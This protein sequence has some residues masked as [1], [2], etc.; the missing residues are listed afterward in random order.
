MST[1]TKQVAKFNSVQLNLVYWVDVHKALRNQSLEGCVYAMDNGID[2]ENQGTD[3]LITNCKQGQTLNWIIYAMDAIQLP[4]GSWPASVRINNIVFLDENGT[5]VSPF[6]L[7]D[8]LAILGGPDKIRAPYTNVY[9]YWAGTIISELPPG[10]YQYRLVL[11]I[12]QGK[13]NKKTYL[14]VPNNFTLNVMPLRED[15]SAAA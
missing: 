11:E 10:K 12:D 14:N 9:Y 13:I 8:E 7:C 15:E 4:D 6:R 3:Q 5:D 2:S 1:E